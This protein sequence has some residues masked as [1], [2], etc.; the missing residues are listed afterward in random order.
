MTTHTLAAFPPDFIWGVATSAYQIEGAWDEDGKGESIW[1][2][3]AHTPGTIVDGTNGDVACDH[4]HRWPEDIA[5]MKS[6]G[7]QAYRF[8][9]S[10]PRILPAGRGTVNRAGLDFYSRLVDGLLEAGITPFVTLYH[11][12]L[13][14]VLQDEG[15]WPARATAEALV[16]YAGVVSRHLGDRVK[17]WITHNEPW[18]I[19]ILS[20]QIGEHAPGLHDG[21]AALRAAH[22][23]L[24]SHGWALPVI[25]SNSPAAAAGITLNLTPAVPASL[26]EADA[27]AARRFDGF[28]NRWFLDPLYGRGYPADTVSDYTALG[29][30][31]AEGLPFVRAG[32]LESIATPTDFLGVNYYTRAILRDEQALDNLPQTTF[33]APESERTTMDWEVYPDGLY[34]ILRRLHVEYRPAK[35]F[36]TENGASYPDEP[37]ANGHVKDLRRLDYLRRHFMAAH[38]AIAEGFPL[39]GYFVWSLVDNFEWARG[40]TQRFGIVLV[41]CKTRRRVPKESALW[42]KDIIAQN[43]PVAENPGRR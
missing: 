1:D 24:L 43:G 31:P 19:S 21:N 37:D 35:M 10:W 41:D 30:L 38:R 17:H 40:Y 36:V 39:A 42:Y 26:S 18:C 29:Y 20:H 12:D 28:F 34:Q 8:S 4:Y 5:L 15:G 22:H 7:I 16:E 14:Q 25:R 9:V 2:R 27:R 11:W 33:P 3:F 32:D 6:L 23:T 13:P